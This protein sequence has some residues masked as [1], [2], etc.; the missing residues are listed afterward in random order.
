MALIFRT[1]TFAR[2]I[3]TGGT[4]RFTTRNGYNGIPADYVEPVKQFAA[5]GDTTLPGGFTF[6]E[7]DNAYEKGWINQQE[8]DDTLDI[9][10][11]RPIQTT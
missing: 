11:P 5:N 1:R 9:K 3:Y 10:G 4:E 8:Y 6:G 7:I 2:N